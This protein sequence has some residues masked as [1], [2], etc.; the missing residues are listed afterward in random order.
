[1]G[2]PAVAGPESERR[3]RRYDQGAT[4]ETPT[5]AMGGGETG[6][7]FGVRAWWDVAVDERMAGRGGSEGV[8]GS[9]GGG[10]GGGGLGGGLEHGV[11]ICWERCV[12]FGGSRE[13]GGKGEA[14][15]GIEGLGLGDFERIAFV[16]GSEA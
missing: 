10:G 16:L 1:M 12:G 5:A 14:R 7:G 3:R 8:R 6:M 11:R 9:W 13:W 4:A 2:H 15:C